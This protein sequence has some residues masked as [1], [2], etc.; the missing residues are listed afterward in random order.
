MSQS[1]FHQFRLVKSAEQAIE[2]Q[3]LRRMQKVS[4]V[5]EEV[6]GK[7]GGIIRLRLSRGSNG[8]ISVDLSQPES[9][10]SL[11]VRSI[12]IQTRT[13]S[14]PVSQFQHRN[15]LERMLSQRV[16]GNESQ[17]ESLSESEEDEASR[18]VARAEISELRT[19]GLVSSVDRRFRT[20]LESIMSGVQNLLPSRH[21]GSRRNQ[22]SS[23]MTPPHVVRTD[24]PQAPR[25]ES[26]S[27]PQVRTLASV[28]E[29][30]A[31][32]VRNQDAREDV[33][34]EIREL[35]ERRPVLRFM[36]SSGMRRRLERLLRN[37]VRHA[38]VGAGRPSRRDTGRR[39]EDVNDDGFEVLSVDL[40]VS[41]DLDNENRDALLLAVRRLASQVS[42]MR[43]EMTRMQRL[44]TA[45]FEMQ[46][47]LAE[48]TSLPRMPDSSAAPSVPQP[49]SATARQPSSAPRPSQSAAAGSADSTP[50]SG[51][52][53]GYP[54]ETDEAPSALHADRHANGPSRSHTSAAATTGE[55]D[56]ETAS[57]GRSLCS[58]CY[59]RRS[60]IVFYRCGHM[61]TCV[62]CGMSLLV[63][64]RPRCPLCRA[65]IEDAIRVYE[66]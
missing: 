7:L 3:G 14:G 32:V 66:S 13:R 46:R 24:A 52:M 12:N 9:S 56:Q 20:R 64:R 23:S 21:R 17:F 47:A 5:Q 16:Q 43:S 58:V 28:A 59:N 49:A 29:E 37:H 11:Q 40:S 55:E 38:R 25:I 6:A 26:R 39:N 48:G 22:N 33:G 57:S 2:L 36:Q 8:A 41:D 44:L 4:T 30:P 34:N 60:A 45:S 31:V 53:V 35:Q 1:M 54:S 50:E 42:S 65:D 19:R 27:V 15:R 61:C 10:S 63:Q 62:S 51:V 18:P